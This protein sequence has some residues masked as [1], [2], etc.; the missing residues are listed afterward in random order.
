M[1]ANI[2]ADCQFREV[3]YVA[4]M[5]LLSIWLHSLLKHCFGMVIAKYN[6]ETHFTLE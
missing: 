6:F 3:V 2:L 5:T 4:N 1:S